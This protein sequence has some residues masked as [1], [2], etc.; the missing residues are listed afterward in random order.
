MAT[1][2]SKETETAS[3]SSSGGG[4]G[5]VW[6]KAEEQALRMA[7]K[8]FP[9][10]PAKKKERW[11]NIAG[12]L[13]DSE[14]TAKTVA[15]LATAFVKSEAADDKT[16]EALAMLLKQMPPERLSA[17]P[18]GMVLKSFARADALAD[19]GLVKYLCSALVQQ[20]LEDFDA[21][22]CTRRALLLRCNGDIYLFV[23]W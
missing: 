2:A 6:S 4:S 10:N 15:M 9:P 7:L 21:Q 11:A 1:F 3:S 13:S 12:E 17:R 20:P 19:A 22:S 8:K 14:F 23:F 16:F 18:L 5:S